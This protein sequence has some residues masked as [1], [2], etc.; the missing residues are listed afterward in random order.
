MSTTTA[1]KNID[2]IMLNC[3]LPVLTIN[4]LIFAYSFTCREC[5]DDEFVDCSKC[6]KEFM[7]MSCWDQ[8]VWTFIKSQKVRCKRCG[9]KNTDKSCQ[10]FK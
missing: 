3:G 7:C 9:Y 1:E 8:G 2:T 4:Q 6:P 10:V 5:F